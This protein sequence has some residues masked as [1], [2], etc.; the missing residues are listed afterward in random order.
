MRITF[1]FDR[2]ELIDE[3]GIQSIPG[4]SERK[5]AI[6]EAAGLEMIPGEELRRDINA[7]FKELGVDIRC[8]E[9]EG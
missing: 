7:F 5:E 1:D 4:L 2:N 6:L 3:N 9:P 8:E